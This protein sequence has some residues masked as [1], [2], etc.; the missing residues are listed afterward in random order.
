MKKMVFFFL[1][2]LSVNAYGRS[3][4]IDFRDIYNSG[5]DAGA[6]CVIKELKGYVKSDISE[7]EFFLRL[8]QCKHECR[9]EYLDNLMKDQLEL[10]MKGE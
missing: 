2:F 1:M 5:F 3:D 7:E 6:H 4:T 10:L 8:E 9:G